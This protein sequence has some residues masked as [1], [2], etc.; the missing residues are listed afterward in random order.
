MPLLVRPDFK[1]PYG[2]LQQHR[3]VA[4]FTGSG[5]Q[6]FQK[7]LIEVKLPSLNF[8]AS[9]FWDGMV[10]NRLVNSGEYGNLGMSFY[11][12]LEED[13]DPVYRWIQDHLRHSN[14]ATSPDARSKMNIGYLQNNVSGYKRHITI[15]LLTPDLQIAQTWEF[16]G[17]QLASVN[18]DQLSY[19]STEIVSVAIEVTPDRVIL[20][21]GAVL[22]NS[23]AGGY[24][25]TAEQI[26]QMAAQAGISQAGVVLNTALGAASMTA[27][28][29]DAGLPG[30][31]SSS[32]P[33]GGAGGSVGSKIVNS[34][35]SGNLASV[36][37]LI[38]K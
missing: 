5:N 25:N 2:Y 13:T 10:K 16:D 24:I 26:A 27:A 20:P 12:S 22:S 32:N 31:P 11:C 19:R 23:P 18:F 1:S 8:A 7:N 37:G 36:L 33:F 35:V 9:E 6:W 34:V 21:G 38:S 30:R 28:V 15:L 29:L 4:L 14:S 17:C 3:F